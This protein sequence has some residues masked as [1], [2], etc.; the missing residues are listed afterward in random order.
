M[1]RQAERRGGFQALFATMPNWEL[2]SEQRPSPTVDDLEAV[3]VI[4]HAKQI[5]RRVRRDM[6]RQRANRE[7]RAARKLPEPG[8]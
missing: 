6:A 7:F 1:N 3:R 2:W 8:S 4:K 5:P